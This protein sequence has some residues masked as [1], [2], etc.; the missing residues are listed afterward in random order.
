MTNIII[1]IITWWTTA[2]QI[3]SM[4]EDNIKMEIRRL[5][6]KDVY[7]SVLDKVTLKHMRYFLSS[8]SRCAVQITKCLLITFDTTNFILLYKYSATCF[9]PYV[10]SLKRFK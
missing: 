9:N 2:E 6:C 3:L 8:I 1:L 4:L 7:R 5:G 10:V